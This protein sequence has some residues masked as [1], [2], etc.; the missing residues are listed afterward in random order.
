MSIGWSTDF[1][2]VAGEL[3]VAEAVQRVQASGADWVLVERA[4][5]TWR[6]VFSRKELLALPERLH[7]ADLATLPLEAALDLHEGM[8]SVAVPVGPDPTDAPATRIDAPSAARFVRLDDQGRPLAVGGTNVAGARRRSTRTVRRVPLARSAPQPM[9]VGAAPDDTAAAAPPAD[10]ATAPAAP[11]AH[12]DEGTAPQ[13]FPSIASDAPLAPGAAVTLV[14]DLKREE[15]DHTLGGFAPPPLAADWTQFDVDVILQSPSIAFD[16]GGR[17]TVTVRRNQDSIAARITGRVAADLAP[18]SDVEVKARFLHGTRSCGSAARRFAL[19][20]AARAQPASTAT[21]VIQVDPRAESPDLTVFITSFDRDAPGALHWRLVT[22]PFDGLPPRL[23]GR[24]DLGRRPAEEATALFTKF[25]KLERGQ[26]REDIEGFGQRLWR[27]AP[28]A[29]RDA[30]WAL[31]DHYR[32]PLTIQFISDDPHLPWELM[33][34]SRD[35]EV[36]PPLALK[37]AVARWI[38]HWQGWMRNRLPAGTLVAVAPRYQSASTRLT[39]AEETAKALVT[40]LHAQRLPGTRTQLLQLLKHPPDEPVALLYFTGHGAFAAD[41]AGASQ[42][43]LEDGQSLTS[44]AVERDE[45]RLGERW[46]TVVFL[47]ACEVG[48]TGSVLGNVGGWADAFLSR[49]FGAFIAPLWAIDEEDAKQATEM[50]MTRIVRDRAPLGQALREL[51]QQYGDVS[52]TFYSYLLYG[53][54]TAR[55]GST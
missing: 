32:R 55:L 37:H 8:A 39:L 44:L 23:D 33:R 47:N 45:V 43:K 41:A 35:G 1:V 46:G 38:G 6:Y 4:G 49:R 24:I 51:R 15:V 34:P 19:G 31:H 21:P 18:G 28:Q 52:P 2:V 48:A 29:F 11:A 13:R 7:G 20:G 3:P 17:G 14:V 5:G 9:A 22:A 54:V 27:M 12:D 30:Y 26:H 10:D 40:T 53:D 36:H 42:L 25:A 16:G 50:L